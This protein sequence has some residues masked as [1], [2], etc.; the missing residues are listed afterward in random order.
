MNLAG[1]D[2]VVRCLH[3]VWE[4]A[5]K[6]Q[7]ATKKREMPTRPLGRSRLYCI[8][9]QEP[10]AFQAL[11]LCLEGSASK[12]LAYLE[13][14]P[15]IRSSMVFAVVLRDQ[16]GIP[17]QCRGSSRKGQELNEHAGVSLPSE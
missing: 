15:P 11:D 6:A 13:I 10:G 12:Y 16:F 14:A 2:H 3:Q 1:Y 8:P 7:R 5:C 4:W 17:L 9:M